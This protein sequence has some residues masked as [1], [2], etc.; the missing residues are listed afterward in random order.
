MNHQYKSFH[1]KPNAILKSNR[2]SIASR[3]KKIFMPLQKAL[4]RPFLEYS[5]IILVTH[6]QDEQRQKRAT[7]M[8][9]ER[10]NLAYKEETKKAWLV[11]CN[12]IKA[13]SA[14]VHIYICISEMY[15]RTSKEQSK[16][17]DNFY[18]TPNGHKLTINIFIPGKNKVK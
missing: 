15:T 1:E 8:I 17:R 4:F 7:R 2:R 3:D 14:Y 9:R 13:E 18:T 5:C 10:E 11:Q 16:L 6:V 12:Y